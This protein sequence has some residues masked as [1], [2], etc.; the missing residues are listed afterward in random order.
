VTRRSQRVYQS[1]VCSLL[2]CFLLLHPADLSDV[3]QQP[4]Q[5][6]CA[7]AFVSV[8]LYVR[9]QSDDFTCAFVHNSV[10]LVMATAVQ[11]SAVQCVAREHEHDGG[12]CEHSARM[13]E[14]ACTQAATR[15]TRMY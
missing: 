1:S 12:A 4:Y 10:H 3:L 6:V 8:R 11:C 2:V 7:S 13:R 9:P 5:A 15:H 14:S